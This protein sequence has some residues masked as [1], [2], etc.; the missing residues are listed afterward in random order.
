MRKLKYILSCALLVSVVA[1]ESI[2]EPDLPFDLEETLNSTG[3]FLRV[4]EVVMPAYDFEDL[5]NASYTFSAEYFDNENSSLLEEIVFYA[6]YT[7]GEDQIPDVERTL[8]KSVPASAFSSAGEGELP[9]TTFD[10][11]LTEVNTALGID[12]NDNLIGDSYRVEWDIVLTDG[13]VFTWED[14]S[15]STT[16]GFYNS[17]GFA[18]VNMVAAVPQDMFVGEYSF[19]PL[20]SGLYG[21]I[22]EPGAAGFNSELEI[23]PD[24]FL[25]GRTFTATPY[26]WW[27]GLAERTYALRLLKA[28]NPADNSATIAGSVSTGLGC[29]G[30]GLYIGPASGSNKG[31]FNIDDDS[32]FTMV[33]AD[34]SL[35]GCSAG[36][37]DVEFTVTKVP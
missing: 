19:T 25:V 14:M 22:W 28:N 26:P 35:E 20:G 18:V 3:A 23:D 12:S 31:T 16:G 30:P 9:S 21:Q 11:T 5:Q 17:P 10:I 33:V 13:R 7:A 2:N 8:V 32:G 1:C 15:Q 6:S 34:N 24:N 27:G 4:T 37:V 36:P 29:G